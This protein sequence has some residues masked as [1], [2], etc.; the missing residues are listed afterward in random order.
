MKDHRVAPAPCPY[1]GTRLD[2]AFNTG[3]DAA[4]TKGDVTICAYCAGLCVFDGEPLALRFPTDDEAADMVRDPR[5][6]RAR[7][8]V[9]STLRMERP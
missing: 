9:M 1:C 5:V 2:G 6:E 7:Q 3:D 8:A 4:P